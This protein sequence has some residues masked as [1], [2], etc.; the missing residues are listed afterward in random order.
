MKPTITTLLVVTLGCVGACNSLKDDQRLA[1]QEMMESFSEESAHDAI[2]RR[3]TVFPYHFI[4]GAPTLNELGEHDLD[5]LANH[6]KDHIMTHLQSHDII[7]NVR[8][9]FDFDKSDIR[10]DAGL[11]LDDA[12]NVLAANPE[13]DLIITGHA[14]ARGSA[15]YND[16]LGMRRA[17]SVR[18]YLASM[19]VDERRI[20]SVSRGK[21]DAIAPVR[22]VAGM[23]ADRKARF[24]VAKIQQFPV[25]LNVRQGDAS[26]DLYDNRKRSVLSFL[27]GCGL[28]TNLIIF[29]DGS[30]G[31]DP[32]DSA[33]VYVIVTNTA[34]TAPRYSQ[35]GGGVTISIGGS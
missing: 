13:A 16:R 11:I 20:R 18:R 14:D 23:Q 27:E 21:L 8:V 30:V 26:N 24:I 28:D 3:G 33:E 29:S 32:R 19:G 15:A 34:Q 12:I 31:G 1:H 17:D 22:D 4:S 2:I 10:S 6:Y 25:P 9:L 7:T 35:R 5:V